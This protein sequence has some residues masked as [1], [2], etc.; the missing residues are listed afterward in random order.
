MTVGYVYIAFL[1]LVLPVAAKQVK[2]GGGG[3]KCGSALFP[4][5]VALQAFEGACWHCTG[6]WRRDIACF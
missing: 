3:L 2:L 5:E 6:R 1:P 4:S